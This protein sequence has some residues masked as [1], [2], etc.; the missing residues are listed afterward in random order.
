MNKDNKLFI[1]II[2]L[3]VAIIF[4]IFLDVKKVD[5]KSDI[6]YILFDNFLTISVF[7]NTV[8]VV[9]EFPNTL[10][11]SK[12]NVFIDGNYYGNY[13]VKNINDSLKIYDDNNNA[14]KYNGS[15]VINNFDNSMRVSKID[16]ENSTLLD[17]SIAT[18][19]LQDEG[20]TTAFDSSN[21]NYIK[22]KADFN[23][24]GSYE[25]IY[26]MSNMFSDVN[27]GFSILFTYNNDKYNIISKDINKGMNGYELSISAIA[28]INSDGELDI[29]VGK[30]KFGNPI[31]CYEIYKSNNMKFKLLKGCK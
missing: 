13:Y 10:L 24:D 31:S 9:N 8:K 25:Y 1:L 23:N 17:Y 21:T 30:A 28:D 20:I 12:V 14:V 7:N 26:S 3:V 5:E 22:Y 19:I 2:I 4:R 29:V 16:V 27:E 18:R 15:L 6:K 11:K